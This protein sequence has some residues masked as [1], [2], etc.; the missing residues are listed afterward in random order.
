MQVSLVRF[1]KVDDM[2]MSFCKANSYIERINLK[3]KKADDQNWP[4]LRVTKAF[5]SLSK[6]TMGC[7]KYSFIA[8]SLSTDKLTP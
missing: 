4:L 7:L 1:Q 6:L 8:A 2:S 3:E 5:K